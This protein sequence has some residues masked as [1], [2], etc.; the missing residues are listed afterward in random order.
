V[1]VPGTRRLKQ[2]TILGLNIL[3]FV[4][5]LFY[6]IHSSHIIVVNVVLLVHTR[7]RQTDRFNR[8]ASAPSVGLPADCRN[9]DRLVPTSCS[10]PTYYAAVV[11]EL[12]RVIC[13][14]HAR[15]IP[16]HIP[17][18]AGRCTA[19]INS[20]QTMHPGDVVA[21]CR[22]T[23]DNSRADLLVEI[24]PVGHVNTSKRGRVA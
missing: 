1:G 11:Q 14:N 9:G 10:V 3:Q 22:T 4:Q 6:D 15:G 19:S 13:H 21:Q 7:R 5:P 8:P 17:Q 18:L 12:R 16:T 20:H 23:L 24:E 2:A